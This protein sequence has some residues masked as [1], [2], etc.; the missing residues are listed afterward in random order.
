V[1]TEEEWKEVTDEWKGE[2]ERYQ[3]T[4]RRGVH[5][6]V[7]RRVAKL[8]T[9]MMH[10]EMP[11]AEDLAYE[12]LDRYH[13]GDSTNLKLAD[14]ICACNGV[15]DVE[16]MMKANFEGDLA[17]FESYFT[18]GRQYEVTE[19]DMLAIDVRVRTF[20]TLK[21][22]Y[23]RV[24][25]DG[26]INYF[27]ERGYGFAFPE[28]IE[29][30]RRIGA[31]DVYAVLLKVRQTLDRKRPRGDYSPRKIE[32]GGRRLAKKLDALATEFVLAWDTLMARLHLWL[33]SEV[34]GIDLLSR[35]DR[36]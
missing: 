26:F 27:L 16:A 28:T 15:P 19:E 23:F 36:E 6:N 22:L 7:G 11:Q 17:R 21:R 3:E 4:A 13:T 35:L 25:S 10:A 31:E 14:V 1:L 2:P 33:V 5:K 29:S 12:H 30:T 8:I 20:L 24:G 32:R 34:K 18:G 9:A